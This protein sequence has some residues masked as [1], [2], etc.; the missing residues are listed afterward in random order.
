MRI[1]L[2]AMGG[3]HAPAVTVAGAV[4]AARLYNIEVIL[5]GDPDAI[6][7][8]LAKHD[9]RGLS[10]PVVP[11][12]QVI[13]MTDHV[14]AVRAK[15]DASMNVGARL[16]RRG[17]ADGFVSA[18]HSGAVMAAALFNIGRIPGIKRP[19]LGTIYPTV[20]G[21]C[22]VLDVGANTECTPLYL[23]QFGLMG[24][25]FMERVYGIPRPTVA[26]VSNGEEEDKG[27]Q[28]VRQTTPLLRDSGL[29]FVGNAEGKDVP[30]G[31]ADVIVTDGFT[32][33][34]VIKLSEGLVVALALIIIN[35]LEA[36][37]LGKLALVLAIPAAVLALP[38][39]LLSIPALRRV[40]KRF[41]YAEFGGAHL[42]GV[43]GPV[44]V[45][46]GRSN[47]KAIQ[48]AIR[49]CKESVEH[50]VVGTIHAGARD[51]S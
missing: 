32:G 22:F 12:S 2:D 38:A 27:S 3:D 16:V 50:D 37:V 48:N 8:E 10:L 17:E 49:V 36:G 43:N 33:N 45:A 29:N 20:K 41:Y 26:L 21:Q 44:I 6:Q 11:A 13:E 4:Q 1:A 40:V 18:G 47:V 9:T 42:M 51:L 28:L 19:A 30:K 35:E 14:D 25:V 24:S 15:K 23:L 46:H 39:L 34:V 5:V 31:F 7:A